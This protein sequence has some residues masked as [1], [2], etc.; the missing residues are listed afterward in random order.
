[1]SVFKGYLKIIQKNLSITVSY[2]A[3]FLAIS[4]MIVMMIPEKQTESFAAQR[5]QITVIDEDESVISK[6][7]IEYLSINNDVTETKMDKAELTRQLYARSTDY[8]LEIPEGFGENFASGDA[9]LNTTKVPDSSAGFY[10]DNMIEEFVRKASAFVNAGYTA[11]EAADRTLD[12][13]TT[14]VDVTIVDTGKRDEN[15]KPFYSYTFTYFPYLYLM[16]MITVIASVM[17]PFSNKEIRS[18][19]L[20]SPISSVSQTL[21]AAAAFC[22]QFIIMWLITL[23]MPLATKGADFYTAPLAGYYVINSFCLL[24][25][26]SAI[27]FLSGSLVTTPVAVS[28]IANILALGM[29]FLCGAFVPM[30]YLGSGVK[31]LAQFLPVYW[32]ETANNTLAENQT[33]STASRSMIFQCYAIQLAF[34]LAIFVVTLFIVKKKNQEA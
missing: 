24:V 32:Y 19:M 3:L 23:L 10:L 16:L 4:I 27:G 33:L 5:Q 26:S 20:A 25:V 7:L 6:A 34:A 17:L 11:E 2:F 14:K 13:V 15:S 29:C 22:I 31:K 9:V 28:A 1:M 18:R 8:V 21:Q 30:E 12:A